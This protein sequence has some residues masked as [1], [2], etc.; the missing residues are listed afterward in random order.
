[1]PVEIQRK[2]EKQL[3]TVEEAIARYNTKAPIGM[4]RWIAKRATFLP[5]WA[6]NT[7]RFHGIT[8]GPISRAAYEGAVGAV[9]ESELVASVTDKGRACMDGAKAGLMA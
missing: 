2:G 1:M 3:K 8:V 4:R 9:T 7:G 5:K 6:A